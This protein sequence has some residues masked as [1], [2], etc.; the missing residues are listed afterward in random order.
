M[1]CDMG[2]IAWPTS[3]EPLQLSWEFKEQNAPAKLVFIMRQDGTCAV[4]PEQLRK[5]LHASG[6]YNR[7][8]I[9]QEATLERMISVLVLNEPIALSKERP[10]QDCFEVIDPP[11]PEYEQVIHND[12]IL[13]GCLK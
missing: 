6:D 2:P 10:S 11:P 4:N 3:I 13:Q 12:P 8:S 7:K 5:W 9:S 1:A